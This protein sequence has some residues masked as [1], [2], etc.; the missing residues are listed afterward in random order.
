LAQQASFEET[1]RLYG[2]SFQSEGEGSIE[3]FELECHSAIHQFYDLS[4]Q[5]PISVTRE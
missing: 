5:A 3:T 2:H 4:S 1:V